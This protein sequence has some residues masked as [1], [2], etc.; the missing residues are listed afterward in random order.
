MYY[1]TKVT[2]CQVLILAFCIFIMNQT[3]HM[4]TSDLGVNNLSRRSQY[5]YTVGFMLCISIIYNSIIPFR[6]MRLQ[7]A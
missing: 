6:E 2:D 3:L 4:F 1:T 7:H 5:Q